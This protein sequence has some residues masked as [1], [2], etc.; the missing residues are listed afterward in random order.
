VREVIAFEFTLKTRRRIHQRRT[1]TLTLVPHS[2]TQDNRNSG[3]RL[4]PLDLVHRRHRED[5]TLDEEK[6]HEDQHNCRCADID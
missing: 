1:Q 2:L 3:K 6:I 5:D 4:R